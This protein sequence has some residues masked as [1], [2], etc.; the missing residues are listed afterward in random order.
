[1]ELLLHTIC[2]EPARWTPKRVSRPLLDLLP[3]IA[4]AGFSQVEIYEPHLAD[5]G[6]WEAIK[7][8]LE[9]H[10]LSARILSSYADFGPNGLTDEGAAE[11]FSRI[12]ELIR[13]FEFRS[14]RLFPAPKV[15]PADRAAVKAF[16]E[17]LRDVATRLPHTEIL[18]ETHDGSIADEPAR[19]VEVVRALDLP[20]V[21][22]LYQPT[23]F[24]DAQAV[25]QFETQRDLIRHV[26]LQNRRAEG[27]FALLGEGT[28]HWARILQNLP[29]GAN[30]SFEFVPRGICPEPEFDLAA[31]LKE[32]EAE[33]L[34]AEQNAAA[35]S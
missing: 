18:L 20:N 9:E 16:T 7:G 25:A 34:W 32:V 12:E 31:V 14:L 5:P 8:A 27:G 13:F 15:H 19:I 22:L 26:H 24:E 29:A 2:L 6:Q 4:A 23:I 1:M 30:A 21:G 17:R 35:R 28:V 3:P 11:A 33:R 10:N